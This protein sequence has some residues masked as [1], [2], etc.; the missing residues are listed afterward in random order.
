MLRE[1]AS[2]FFFNMIEGRHCIS[3]Y[4]PKTKW[5]PDKTELKQRSS[6]DDKILSISFCPSLTQLQFMLCH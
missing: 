2:F 3:Q 1:C 6:N 5:Q 4:I